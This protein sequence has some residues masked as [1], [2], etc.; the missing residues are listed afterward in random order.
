MKFQLD[1]ELLHK[2]GERREREWHRMLAEMNEDCRE[3]GP[4]EA[5]VV[6]TLMRRSDGGA[7]IAVAAGQGERIVPLSMQRLGS[8]FRD[9]RHMIEQLDRSAG[10]F[11]PRDLET[12]DYAKKLVHDEA[13]DMVQRALAGVVELEHAM[14]RR[15]FTL[16][17]LTSGA[18]PDSLGTRYRHE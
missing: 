6:L 17:F 11:G 2:A 1:P 4:P 10:G 12:L 7:D 9:Y 14:A 15:L 5:E 16:V 3:A 18:V 8:H 13:A